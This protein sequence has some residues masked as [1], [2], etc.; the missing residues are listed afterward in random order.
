MVARSA[1]PVGTARFNQHELRFH[2]TST[3]GSGKAD[4]FQTRNPS[5]FVLGVLFDIDPKE[6]PALDQSETGYSPTNVVVICDTTEKTTSTL[7][8]LADPKCI[9]TKLSPYS[10]YLA[11]VVSGAEEHGLDDAYVAGLRS[12]GAI[13]DR[14]ASRD[15]KRRTVLPCEGG[16]S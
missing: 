11:L 5:A 8:Y 10:W 3:D 2:K 4:A 16:G 1:R 7:T 13:V 14:N 15:A 6:K 12:V 9:N